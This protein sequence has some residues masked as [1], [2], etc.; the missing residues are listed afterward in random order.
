[1]AKRPCCSRCQTQQVTGSERFHAK[2]VA[3]EGYRGLLRFVSPEPAPMHVNILSGI[4]LI[5]CCHSHASESFKTLVM[6]HNPNSL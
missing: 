5:P 4:F 2:A 6:D 1:M 3:G